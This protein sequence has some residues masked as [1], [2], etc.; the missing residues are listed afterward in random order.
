MVPILMTH[1]GDYLRMNRS[2][3]IAVGIWLGG[4][5]LGATFYFAYLVRN[6]FWNLVEFLAWSLS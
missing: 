6:A 3:E 1:Q 4:T 2:T 5:A